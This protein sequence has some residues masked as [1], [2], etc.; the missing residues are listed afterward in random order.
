LT[1]FS[2]FIYRRGFFSPGDFICGLEGKQTKALPASGH[3][4]GHKGVT[5]IYDRLAV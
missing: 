2:A 4:G 5:L 1:F 3:K